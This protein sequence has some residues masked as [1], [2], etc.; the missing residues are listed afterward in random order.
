MFLCGWLYG[1]KVLVNAEYNNYEV[2]KL[3]LGSRKSMELSFYKI[4]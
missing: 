1:L 3:N 4:S 2:M